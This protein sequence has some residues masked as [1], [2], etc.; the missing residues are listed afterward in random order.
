MNKHF[1]MRL[2]IFQLSDENI[3][4]LKMNLGDAFFVIK[5]LTN[6]LSV[7]SRE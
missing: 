6:S 2:L 5:H 3:F 1:L 4:S 7:A